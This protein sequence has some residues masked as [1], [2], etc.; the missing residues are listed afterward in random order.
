MDDV[1]KELG[2]TKRTI[3]YYEEIGL[4]FPPERT[5]GGV[6]LYTPEHVEVLRR[7]VD[8]RDVLGFSLQEISDYVSIAK[9]LDE[10]RAMYRS[11][12]DSALKLQQLREVHEITGKQL[13]MIDQKFAKML[14]LR[15][16][17]EQL[18]QRVS[19]IIE[20]Q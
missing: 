15:K 19:E 2:L 11:T 14:K 3:R 12:E 20:P 13:E 8:A 17:I 18:H 7:I 16:E 9:K 10:H 1:A 4:L 6:R 5:S